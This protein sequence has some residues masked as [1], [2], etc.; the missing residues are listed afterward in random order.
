METKKVKIIM[1]PTKYGNI[2]NQKS[3]DKSLKYKP[4]SIVK[5]DELN[6]AYHLYFLLNEEIKEGDWY[7]Y[8]AANDSKNPKWEIHQ[9]KTVEDDPLVHYT[10]NHLT[11]W[12]SKIIATTDPKLN[13]PH[14]TTDF[15]KAFVKA[16]GI[17]EVMVEYHN[18]Y[19]LEYYT[20][21]DG[22]E[23]ARKIDNWE[24]KVNYYNEIT[25]HPIKDCWSR[26]EVI[27]IIRDYHN[28]YVRGMSFDSNP[29]QLWVKEKFN[30]K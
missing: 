23:C 20:P 18:N 1:L 8:N 15:I 27:S 13:L 14:P 30:I 16:G 26:E 4:N 11:M 22:I 29:Y 10:D 9:C 6:T 2:Y 3:M 17:D 24:L 19:D 25:I 21:A 28:K 7:A 5:T 12:C